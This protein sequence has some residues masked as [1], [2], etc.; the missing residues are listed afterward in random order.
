[1]IK[2]RTIKLNN[3]GTMSDAELTLFKQNEGVLDCRLESDSLYIKYDLGKCTYQIIHTYL[4]ERGIINHETGL[5]R[6]INQIIF[7]MEKNE[8]DY[9]AIPYGWDYYV[10]SLYLCLNVVT[11]SQHKIV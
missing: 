4:N 1:M 8:R 7:S 5:A 11:R 9:H 2:N 10:Q 6:W 3:E